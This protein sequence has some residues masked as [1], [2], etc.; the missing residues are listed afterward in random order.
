MVELKGI[1]LDFRQAVAAQNLGKV[2]FDAALTVGV[3][4][5]LA[6]VAANYKKRQYVKNA[7][8][9]LIAFIITYAF[10]RY[11]PARGSE[12]ELV[13]MLLGLWYAAQVIYNLAGRALK[14]YSEAFTGGWHAFRQAI[15]GKKA[16]Q[17]SSRQTY[18]A[19]QEASQG[20]NLEKE[21][22]TAGPPPGVE[23]LP[24]R[25][26][27]P[28]AFDGLIGLDKAIDAIKTALELPLKQPEKIREYNLELPR[29]ILLYGP[30][31]TGKTS[32][33]R[34]AARYFGCSF[35]AVNASSLIG[36]YVGTSEANLR[37]LFAH[38]RRHR[39]AV[40]FFDE[41]DAIGRRRDGSDMNRASDILLQLLLGELDGFASREGI[42]II[43]ATN[44]ADVLDEALVRP[45][46]LDQKI[47]LPLPGARARRQLFEVYLRNRPTELNETDYQTLVARTEGTSGADIKAI[48]DRAAL[49]ASRVRARIDCAYLIEAINELRGRG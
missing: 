9:G 41:I 25:R 19:Y 40:I 15:N 44:R 10:I 4:V 29:G 6:E 2:A 34:A 45:G 42:F 39:P 23:Y 17:H 28:R 22:S 27:D 12:F 14:T 48:C 21:A 31:G 46:R 32:F 3:L 26:P 20:N 43:A 24:P 37:N 7:M 18:Q 36:R 13:T 5:L 8:V 16:Y 33:A 47:E 30:P 35:Y 1:I 38:A 49:A 11:F